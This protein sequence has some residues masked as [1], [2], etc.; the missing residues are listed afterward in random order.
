YGTQAALAAWRML[1]FRPGDFVPDPARSDEWNRGAYLVRGPGHCDACH[2]SR[3]ALGAVSHELDLGGGL[4]PM[5]NWYAPPLVSARGDG[6]A[7]WDAADLEALLKTGV[8]PRGAAM[9]PMAEVV[10]RSTQHLSDADVRAIAVF[11]RSFAAPAPARARAAVPP[12][13]PDVL[14]RGERIYGDHCADCH[15]RHGTGQPP[16][17]PALAGNSSVTGDIA[18]NAI[19]AVL[20]GGYAPSTASHPRPYG[21]PPFFHVLKDAD[22]AAVLTYVRTSWGRGAPPVSTADVERYRDV[23]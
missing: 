6:A 7:N 17:Y 22:V 20:F 2:A 12:A 23:R 10:Y 1:F 9:G 13:E 14:A 3:N 15:G 19:K 21:M 11:L 16:A 8:S 18:A 5:Q 4:I